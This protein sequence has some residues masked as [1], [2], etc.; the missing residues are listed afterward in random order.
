MVKSGSGFACI[1]ML[2]KSVYA[3]VYIRT[4]KYVYIVNNCRRNDNV[5]VRLCMHKENTEDLSPILKKIKLKN[6]S[7]SGKVV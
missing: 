3:F 1:G 7:G 4:Y 5:F 2:S 6:K